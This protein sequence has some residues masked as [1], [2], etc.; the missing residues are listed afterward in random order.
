MAPAEMEIVG[1]LWAGGHLA[2]LNFIPFVSFQQTPFIS[3]AFY[4]MNKEKT[5]GANQPQLNFSS[6]KLI[7]LL[8][9]FVGGQRP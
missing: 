1:G 5:S 6:I 7:G 9:W 2:Q 3:F 8:N 4:F